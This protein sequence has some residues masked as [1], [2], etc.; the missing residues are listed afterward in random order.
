MKMLKISALGLLGM[1]IIVSCKKEKPATPSVSGN[2]GQYFNS[3]LEDQKQYFTVDATT[4]QVI[5]GSQGTKIY[6][7][8]NNLAD[9]N[10]NLIT[11]NVNVELVE[12]YKKSSMVLSKRVTVANSGGNLVPISSGGE[13][14]IEFTQNGEVLNIV[15]PIY[16]ST[17]PTPDLNPNMQYFTGTVDSGN[18]ITWD[19]EDSTVVSTGVDTTGGQGLDYFYYFPILSN[20]IWINCDYFWGNPSLTTPIDVTLPSAYN[21]SNANV[22][23]VFQSENATLSLYND[24]LSNFNYYGGI[25][26]GMDV[27]FVVVSEINDQLQYAI[28]ESTIVENHQEI[29][30]SSSF[31]EVSDMN[32]LELILDSYF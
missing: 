16:A 11:G 15:N 14:F 32:A 6:L 20:T 18:N 22:F 25:P 8:G 1:L 10:G 26:T 23:C 27:F 3:Y 4:Y 9:Q 2:V 30:N 7:N 24:N 5:T 12:I 28:V 19:L 17:V 21:A 31:I 13:F 29:I